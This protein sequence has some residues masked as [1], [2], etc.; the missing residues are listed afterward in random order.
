M[1]EKI[2]Q[3]FIGIHACFGGL[4]LITGFIALCVTK[5]GRLHK[6]FGLVFYYSM[7]ISALFAFVIS[8]MPNHRSPFLF[9]IGLF[10]TYFLVS[11]YRS[12]KF[13]DDISGLKVDKIIGYTIGI[14]GIIMMVYPLIFTSKINIILLVFGIMGLLSGIQD[15]RLYKDIDRVKKSWLILHINKM[16]GGYIAAVSAFFVVNQILPGI[17]NWFT[18]GIVGAFYITY[19]VKKIKK[20]KSST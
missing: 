6:K 3:L 15:I 18:P 19:W 16:T 9:C 5:G 20:S 11:G 4:A 10:S 7:L 13:K 1:L 12:L 17:W 2:A 14:T 8:V